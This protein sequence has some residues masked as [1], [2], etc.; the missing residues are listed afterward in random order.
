MFE[1]KNNKES[2]ISYLLLFLVIF[3]MPMIYFFSIK[4]FLYSTVLTKFANAFADSLIIF[5]LLN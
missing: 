4:I 3:I 1:I 5:S 2:V